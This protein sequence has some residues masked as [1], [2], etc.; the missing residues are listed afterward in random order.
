MPLKGVDDKYKQPLERSAFRTSWTQPEGP[1]DVL[2][3]EARILDINLVNWTVDCVTVFDGKRF[4]D[5][6]VAA[7]YLHSNQGEGIYTMPE[8]GA[9]CLVCVP[10]DGPPPFVLAFVMPPE[11]ISDAGSEQA[12]QGTQGGQGGP[13]TTPTDSTYSGG[14]MRAKPGDIVMKGR[15]GNFVVLHRG[16]VLQ[17]GCSQLAQRIFIPLGNLVTDISQNYNHFNTGGSVNWGVRAESPEE[18]QETEYRHTFRVFANDEFADIRLAVGRIH[19]IVPEKP[20]EDSSAIDLEQLQ[21]GTD[22]DVVFE[23]VLA[24]GGFDTDAGQPVTNAR[25][26]TKLKFFFDRDGNTM[27]RSEGSVSLRVKKKLRIRVDDTIEVF[28]KKSFTLE[29]D[30]IA[31]IRGGKL[32]EL[33]TKDGQVKINGGTKPVAHVGSQILITL[34]T[35]VPITTSQGPGTILAGATFSGSVSTGNPSILV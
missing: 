16:G 25:D 20:G 22:A 34:V 15:D 8:V 26:L 6:Q 28:G 35:P 14:R 33:T 31:R 1:S 29:C 23:M 3:H 11:A 2:I 13:T 17:I 9:K 32:L 21:I 27:F 4:F 30:D 12:P 24:P 5:I 7:P 10:S 18:N 19:Q